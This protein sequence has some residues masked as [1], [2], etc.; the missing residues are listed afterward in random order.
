MTTDNYMRI[1]EHGSSTDGIRTSVDG[2]GVEDDILVKPV[3][4]VLNGKKPIG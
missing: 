1:G 2:K 3:E 4:Q